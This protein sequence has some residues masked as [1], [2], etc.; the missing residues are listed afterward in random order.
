MKAFN[1]QRIHATNLRKITETD[2]EKNKMT[3]VDIFMGKLGVV[4]AEKQ[5][6]LLLIVL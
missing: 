2:F 6:G 4:R 5:R 1:C 3:L